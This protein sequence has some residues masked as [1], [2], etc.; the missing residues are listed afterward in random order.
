M[1]KSKLAIQNEE[2]QRV[3]E[4]LKNRS[5]AIRAK[6][7]RDLARSFS[8]LLAK[9]DLFF[10]RLEEFTTKLFAAN[11]IK[12]S[13]YALKKHNKPIKREL[14]LDVSDTHFRAMLDEREL[15]KKY[16]QV[17]EA[18]RLAKVAQ[19]AAEFKPHYRDDTALNVNLL[20]DMIQGILLHDPRDGAPLAEQVGAAIH[21]LVQMFEFLS[22]HFPKINIRCTPGNHGRNP[23]RHAARAM[24][25]KW[26]AF[27]TMIYYSLKT[28][29]A[30]FPNITVEIPY[31]PY[32]IYNSL[33]HYILGTHGDT[34]IKVGN[35]DKNIDVVNVT[36]QINEINAAR[37]AN[38]KIE[39]VTA[40]HVHV[41][42]R[43]RLSNGVVLITNGALIPP[44]G[45][46]VNGVGK[47][48]STCLQVLWE[49]T[50]KHVAGDYREL[51]VD[52][53]DDDK[54]LD[55]IIK[56]FVGF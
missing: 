50:E 48:E 27:E 47:M 41:G 29:L 31:T 9:D 22:Q 3:L 30:R 25:Q 35:P 33:G 46:M 7:E 20:G 10:Q 55:A 5:L 51:T 42:S 45:F 26:D 43:T 16:Q 14:H 1:S 2:N 40:G 19:E 49:S 6:E 39:I 28:A 34:F 56:P 37:P 12:P 36:K 24:H 13:R 17:E 53:A 23:L 38:E 15:P 44:D 32:F 4:I 11:P 8:V 21:L 54:G 52:E 18:R